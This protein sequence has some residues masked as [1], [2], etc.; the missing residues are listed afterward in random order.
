M[1]KWSGWQSVCVLMCPQP[2]RIDP[3]ASRQGYDVRSDVWSLG[4]TLVRRWRHHHIPPALCEGELCW[5]NN[6][7]CVCFSTSWPLAGSLTLSGIVFSISWLRWWKEN[8]LS[9][10][11]QR[12]GSSPPSSL[13]SSTYGNAPSRCHL[14]T[15]WCSVLLREERGFEG[16]RSLVQM[17]FL[18]PCS[19]TKDES[20]RPKYKE[21][22]V[23]LLPQFFHG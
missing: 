14:H 8:P 13:T 2:E 23:S 21:L 16:A 5:N 20:K 10:A 12:R 11:T 22:L 6:I 1:R 9:S 7:V 4:I 17:C 15:C 19:L 3:S 18:S